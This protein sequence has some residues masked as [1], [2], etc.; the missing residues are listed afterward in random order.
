LY[1][2]FEGGD[3]FRKLLDL[4]GDEVRV[5]AVDF[6]GGRSGG[7]LKRAVVGGGRARRSRSG[8]G[9]CNGWGYR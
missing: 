8:G 3:R 4:A 6:G 9:D 7:N 2:I 5:I 1:S